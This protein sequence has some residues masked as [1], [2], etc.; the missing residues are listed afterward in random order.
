M[1]SAL[2]NVCSI[3]GLYILEVTTISIQ[4][5]KIKT[6]PRDCQNEESDPLK[7]ELNEVLSHLA[8]ARNQAWVLCRTS[9]C[10]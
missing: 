7:L 6:V 2:K 5:R 9:K 1:S 10:S 8:Y 4:L 3:P